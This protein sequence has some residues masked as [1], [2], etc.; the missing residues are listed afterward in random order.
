MNYNTISG[1]DDKTVERIIDWVKTRGGIAAACWHIKVPIDFENYTIGE[2]LSAKLCTFKIDS[3]FQ[4]DKCIIEGSKEKTYWDLQIEYLATQLKKLQNEN[5]PLIFRPLHEAEGN[6]GINGEGAWFWWGKSGA[7]T[8]VKIWKYLYNKLT[9]EYELHNLIWEQNLYIHTSDSIKWYSGK[10]YVDIIGYDK[11]NVKNNRHDGKTSGPNLSAETNIFYNLF[12]FGENKKMVALAENDSIP[13]VNDLITKKAGWLYFSPWY[14][15]YL[16]D[17]NINTK[18]DI[19]EIYTN[20]YCVTL[21][22]LPNLLKDLES[23]ECTK[24]KRI[25]D[26]KSCTLAPTKK[27]GFKCVLKIDGDIK[28]CIEEKKM[29]LEIKNDANEDICKNSPS[30]DN[31]KKCKLNVEKGNECQEYNN[32]KD[33]NEEKNEESTDIKNDNNQNN[34]S[35]NNEKNN[36]QENNEYYYKLSLYLFVLFLL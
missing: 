27:V 9:Q 21:E 6:G 24:V 4:T 3:N 34:N 18:S 13:G 32:N 17:E 22:D 19:K 25:Y 36:D 10:D 35:D 14:G 29:C 15:D 31:S 8:Y 33:E 26:E 12:K 23:T 2:R 5:I 28:S 1:W 16:F 30:S 7:E 20:D 11:Y